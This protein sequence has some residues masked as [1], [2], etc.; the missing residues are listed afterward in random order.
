[1]S[2]LNHAPVII[3]FAA[4]LLA[5]SSNPPTPPRAP[6]QGA[7]SEPLSREPMMRD[8]VLP[9]KLAIDRSIREACGVSD[10]EAYFAYDSAMVEARH[11]NVLQ[12]LSH[13]FTQGPMRGRAML[14]VGHADPRGDDAYN[15]ALGGRRA[16]S[17]KSLLVTEGLASHLAQTSSRGE[18][19]ANG[20]DESTWTRDR[21]VDVMLV[22]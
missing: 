14:L 15:L 6:A 7:Q 17:V 20:V 18:M 3:G 16:D 21:R 13:C 9:G 8:E 4:L 1:M 5:C 22:D 10:V 2:K 19:D 12:K 11:R